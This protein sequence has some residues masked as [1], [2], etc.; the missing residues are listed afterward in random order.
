M[1]FIC[2]EGENLTFSNLFNE[3][4]AMEVLG[5]VK[6]GFTCL[7]FRNV[8]I[9]IMKLVHPDLSRLSLPSRKYQFRL[10]ASNTIGTRS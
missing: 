2:Q 1:E 3:E 10:F 8:G 7:T 5:S 6:C 4:H 9:K